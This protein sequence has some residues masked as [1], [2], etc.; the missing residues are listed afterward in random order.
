MVAM[1]VL[2]KVA[3]MVDWK[4]SLMAYAL[5]AWKV[6]RTVAVM[7]L[8]TAAMMEE[9]WAGKWELWLVEKKVEHVADW[10]VDLLAEKTVF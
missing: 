8:P 3:L 5:V 9:Y 7:E 10:S 2:L 1:M 6:E 4:E